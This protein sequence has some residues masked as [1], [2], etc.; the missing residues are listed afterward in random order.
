MS[1]LHP[2]HRPAP[3][4]ANSYSSSEAQPKCPIL[5]AV[6]LA[7]LEP[8]FTHMARILPLHGA[9][10]RSGKY[11]SNGLCFRYGSYMVWKEIGGFT[12]EAVVP[13][14]LYAGQLALNW[15]WPPIFFGARQMGWVS[16]TLA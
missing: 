5:G 15:T 14:G 2:A 9:A 3:R 13:L 1:F 4:L 11:L 6:P 10:A 7:R 12:E 8:L 16:V